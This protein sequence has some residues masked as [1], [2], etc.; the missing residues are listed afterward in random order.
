[1]NEYEMR[2]E[3]YMRS[4]KLM[5]F[6]VVVFNLHGE[7]VDEF[8]NFELNNYETNMI[9]KYADYVVTAQDVHFRKNKGY[10]ISTTTLHIQE[11]EQ[12]QN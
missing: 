1:M 11:Q 2:F 5:Y 12:W 10:T 4:Q 9:G 8:D 7:Y 3:D 6:K